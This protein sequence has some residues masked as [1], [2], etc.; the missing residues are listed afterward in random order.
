MRL[1]EKKRETIK[2]FLTTKGHF[3]INGEFLSGA[4]AQK[5]LNINER[6]FQLLAA[7]GEFE[8]T[9]CFAYIVYGFKIGNSV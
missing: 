3:D 8:R 4:I 2:Y 9:I 1:Q 7:S 5:K 6:A